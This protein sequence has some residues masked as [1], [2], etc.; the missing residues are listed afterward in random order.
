M[1]AGVIVSLKGSFP[2]FLCASYKPARHPGTAIDLNPCIF[3]SF[4]TPAHPN[5]SV[6][7]SPVSSNMLG[8]PLRGPFIGNPITPP[9]FPT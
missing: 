5:P 3:S 9:L 7:A 1:I 4:L 8:V 6:D 2:N